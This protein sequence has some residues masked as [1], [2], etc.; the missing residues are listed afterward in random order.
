MVDNLLGHLAPQHHEL[1]LFDINY[2]SVKSAIMVSDPRPLIERLMAEDTLPFRLT[3]ITNERPKHS[4]V[5]SRRKE[6]VSAE[7]SIAPLD[8]YWPAEVISL[9]HVALPIPPD[10]PL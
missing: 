10:D 1:L 8:L 9:S 7:V 6:P 5:V 3:L 4:R 2:T